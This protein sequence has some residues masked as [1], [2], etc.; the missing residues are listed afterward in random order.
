[1]PA[2]PIAFE[3]EADA[4]PDAELDRERFGALARAI[5]EAAHEAA[6]NISTTQYFSVS[7]IQIRVE[8]NPGPTAYKVIITPAG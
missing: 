3:A 1:M 2:K 4:D 8:P 6:S 5:A 7:N